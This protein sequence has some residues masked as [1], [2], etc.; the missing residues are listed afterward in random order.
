MKPALSKIFARLVTSSIE[1]QTERFISGQDKV[2][3][4]IIREGRK[5]SFG[6]DHR[7]EDVH[8][9]DE[10]QA[11]VPQRDYEG[12]Q[13]YIQQAIEG[14]PDILWPGKPIC[15]CKTSG[16]T[17]GVKFI[18]LTKESM[19]CHIRGA[20]NALLSHIA[21]TGDT[22]FVGGKMIFLQGSPKL[23]QLPSGIP[24][25]RLSGIVANH[26][27][28]YLQSNRMPSYD[29]NCIDDWE[30]K[31]DAIVAETLVEDMR[32]IS[33]IP[34]WVIMYFERLLSVT[35]KSKI[36][37]VFPNF[38]LFVYGGV[39][40]A[41]YRKKFFELIGSEMPSVE[42]YPA[43]EGF[44]AYQ[45]RPDADG[46]L[47]NPNAGIFFEFVPLEEWDKDQATRLTLKDVKLG[48]Q[49]V[50]LLT[51][52]AGLW[53]YNI[54]D[55][56]RF[57]SLQPFRIKVTG[58]VQHY[59]SAFGE[60]VISEEVEAAAAHMA[61]R[62]LISI[63]EFHVAP[64]VNPTEG[65]PYHEWIIECDG[66][67]D[68]QRLSELADESLSAKNI[69]YRDLIRGQVLRSAVITLV[70]RGTFHAYMKAEGK[71]GGQNKIPRLSNHRIIADKLISIAQREVNF[72]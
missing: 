62:G 7:L 32:L 19:P 72:R 31:V 71:L 67:A 11:A 38:S 36:N 25:G 35:G 66:E 40:F 9:I 43:S 57:T 49:Y 56:V 26:V 27:P 8:R 29:T 34:S 64:Q 16:T 46:L 50:I 63:L 52:T 53:C 24:Y 65:L 44:I 23:E 18:P 47:L 60:H 6:R 69:Y 3:N 41:P 20:R 33:G 59:T 45:D 21:V 51:T 28:R 12:H 48:V 37:K 14:K 39:Q 22:S 42:L 55:T 30:Q 70:P 54:G 13:Y 15:F 1:K 61:M 5:T 58:R 68:K 2:F 4:Y 10:F 17:S